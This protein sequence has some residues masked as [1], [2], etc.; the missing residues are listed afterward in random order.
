MRKDEFWDQGGPFTSDG[1]GLLAPKVGWCCLRVPRMQMR[2][3]ICPLGHR[4]WPGQEEVS[5]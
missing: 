3:E 1:L 4:L 2:P 5:V